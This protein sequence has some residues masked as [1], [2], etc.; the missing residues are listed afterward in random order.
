MK[1]NGTGF[2]AGMDLK[3]SKSFGLKMIRAFAQKLKA[4]LDIYNN[5]GAVVEMEISKF[6]TA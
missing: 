5:E 4:R 3:N 1:D 2:P 6:K